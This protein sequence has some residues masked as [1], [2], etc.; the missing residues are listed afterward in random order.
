MQRTPHRQHSRHIAEIP[1][2]VLMK[3]GKRQKINLPDA[4]RLKIGQQRHDRLV[5]AA[6]VD[7]EH[8][9]FAVS[10][11]SITKQSALPALR[12]CSRPLIC[13]LRG[14]LLPFAEFHAPAWC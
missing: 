2:M 1:L 8:R 4:V 12:Q 9:L 3:M 6:P 7:Q 5:F 14:V 13:I 11:S 10:S